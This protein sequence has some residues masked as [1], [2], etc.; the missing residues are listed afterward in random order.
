M[1]YK[2]LDYYYMAVYCPEL[3]GMCDTTMDCIYCPYRDNDMVLT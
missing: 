3:G 2:E 1:I